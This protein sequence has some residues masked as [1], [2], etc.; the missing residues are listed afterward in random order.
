MTG[1]EDGR[2]GSPPAPLAP[3]TRA[4]HPVVILAA[5]ESA[6]TR[7][8]GG[9]HKALWPLPDEPGRTWIERQAA[10]LAEA[11]LPPPTVVVSAE[12]GLPPA[13]AARATLNP[14]PARGPFSSAQCGIAAALA[15][16]SD[17]R[18]VFILP[19]DV[20]APAAATWDALIGTLGGPMGAVVPEDARGRGGHPVLLGAELARRYLE[21]D[22]GHA[23]AR[24]DVLL[25]ALPATRMPVPDP[26]ILR[27]LNAPEAL[28][29]ELDTGPVTAL[30]P[31]AALL[32]LCEAGIGGLLHG[33]HVPLAGYLLSTN[34]GF[35]LTFGV[36]RFR[37]A[38]RSY[39]PASPFLV[40]SVAA[41]L[42]TLA[43]AGKKLTPM[44]A[45]SVQGGLFA[46]G[47][48]LCGPTLVGAAL[49]SAI[50]STWAFA[51]P[52]LIA[53]LIFGTPLVDAARETLGRLQRIEMLHGLTPGNL[54]AALLA[55]VALKAA[56]AVGLAV[57]AWRLPEGRRRAWQDRLA[58]AG[59]AVLRRRR[60]ATSREERPALAALRDL[61][62]PLFLV[63]FGLTALFWAF[64]DGGGE[65]LWRLALR[66]LAVGYLLFFVARALPWGR[67]LDGAR[68]S[69]HPRLRH[70][71]EAV[72]AARA[73]VVKCPP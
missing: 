58:R 34:Q 5:G 28:D 40:S 25:R 32:A 15:E 63:P 57:T 33:A 4:L 17:A 51:Q 26:A 13:L 39:A 21:I 56:L 71:A 12:L 52:A 44:L 22:P 43:P 70:W 59:G 53:L 38:P 48:A 72:D 65:S 36:R 50:A 37:A 69:R 35:L 8:G 41:M 16:H 31:E 11:G 64:A 62:S 49:G 20:P 54:G 67:W 9:P 7:A 6:R 14:R 45:I 42:K 68:A 24:L 60:T 55:L 19:V 3:G 23:N 18:G 46:L 1:E 27:D 61:L 73:L 47:P 10:R 2:A 30:G 66:P 29:A